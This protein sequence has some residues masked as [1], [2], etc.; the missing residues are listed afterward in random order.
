MWMITTLISAKILDLE[1]KEV[2]EIALPE[3]FKAPVRMDIIHRAVVASWTRRLQPQGRDPMAGK[4]TTAESRGVG[5]GIARVP[6]IQRTGVAR[7]ASMTVG[8]RTTHPPKTTKKIRKMINKKE[9]HLAFISALSAT[10]IPELVKVRGHILGN[11]QLPIV[12]SKEA[13]NIEKTN[14]VVQL[15]EKLGFKEELDRCLEKRKR[16]KDRVRTPRG[17]LLV[18][19]GRCRLV[20]AAKSIPGVEVVSAQKVSVGDLAPGGTPGRLTIWTEPSLEVLN[21]RLQGGKIS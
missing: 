6:R 16:L 11:R 2:G 19:S 12:V 17:P 1:G 5:F 20:A 9:R 14:G 7:F 4:R 10:A 15:L 18:V 8:G 3:A 21:K 13:E